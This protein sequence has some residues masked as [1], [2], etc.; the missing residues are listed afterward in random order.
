LE[1]RLLFL[2]T[3]KSEENQPCTLMIDYIVYYMK[4][5]GKK[6]PKVFKAVKKTIA[7]GQ[8]MSIKK[9]H[10]FVQRSTR[11]HYPGEHTIHVQINGRKYSKVDFMLLF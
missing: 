4:A 3:I 2:F 10:S 6:V 9:K 7:P 5:N 8:S 1:K 11:V